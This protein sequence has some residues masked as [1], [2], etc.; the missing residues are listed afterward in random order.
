MR[1][2]DALRLLREYLEASLLP[3]RAST[4][5]WQYER[6]LF[7]LGYVLVPN[8]FTAILDGRFPDHLPALKEHPA[9][10]M[11]SSVPH[12]L[13]SPQ[14]TSVNAPATLV[15]RYLTVTRNKRGGRWTIWCMTSQP[16]VILVEYVGSCLQTPSSTPLLPL[17]L[18]PQS[19]IEATL[20]ALKDRN[21]HGVQHMLNTHP[22]LVGQRVTKY[23]WNWLHASARFGYYE[24][25]DYLSSTYPFMIRERLLNQSTPLHQ[26]AYHGDCR[27]ILLLCERGACLTT[28]TVGNYYPVHNACLQ[29]HR[30]AVH[31][32]LHQM[33]GKNYFDDHQSPDRLIA[34]NR[35][36]KY[37]NIGL[38]KEWFLENGI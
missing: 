27:V 5:Y 1:W 3:L 10:E 28:T 17:P 12:E 38:I 20:R 34:R 16:S 29:G 35:P 33:K 32:L 14:A 31:L 21:L 30:D 22:T 36:S 23:G 15:K 2:E 24:A 4:Y 19:F 6:R 11:D 18:P 26:A 8:N 9:V 7:E 37:V 13:S 25:A